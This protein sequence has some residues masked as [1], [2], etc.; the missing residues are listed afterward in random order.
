[1]FR[2]LHHC[3]LVANVIYGILATFIFLGLVERF[4]YLVRRNCCLTLR[5]RCTTA[6][7]VSDEELDQ[8]QNIY[9]ADEGLLPPTLPSVC[10]QL[11]M[12]NEAAVAVRC[13]DA[14]CSMDWPRD[15][16]EVQVLDDSTD[17]AVR[18][19]VDRVAEEW[20]R[21]GVHC[22]VVRRDVR[23]G[24]KAGALE[25][26]R[27]QTDAEFLALFD[28]DFVPRHDFLRRI[29]SRFY[30]R[31]DGAPFTD[32][33]LV[34]AQWTHLNMGQSV[35]TLAQSLW[36]DDHH[37][38]QMNW[39][40]EQW[41]FVNFTGTAGVWRAS[42][43]EA[44]G[45]WRATSLVEDCELS[46]RALFAGYRTTFAR[47]EVPAELPSSVT[48]YKA[49]QKRWTLGWAQ[50][51][52]MHLGTLLFRYHCSLAKRIHLLY[53]IL[54]SVQWPLWL[55]WQ[56]ITPWL[57]A[58]SEAAQPGQ[59]RQP[60]PLDQLPNGARDL[61][62]GGSM[63]DPSGHLIHVFTS[64]AH[65]LRGMIY[66]APL[67]LHMFLAS[68]IAAAER[69]N[70]PDVRETYDRLVTRAS[71]YT[72]RTLGAHVGAACWSSG[73]RCGRPLRFLLLF[74]RALPT[75]FISAGMLPHQACAWIEG[76]FS[77]SSEFET[78]PKSGSIGSGDARST[79]GMG[80]EDGGTTS[81]ERGGA[82]P[83]RSVQQAKVHW[84][85]LAEVA[86]V[87]YQFTWFL[88]FLSTGQTGAAGGTALPMLAVGGL[89][90]CYGDDREGRASCGC[91]AH[92]LVRVWGAWLSERLARGGR[93]GKEAPLQSTRAPLLSEQGH[94]HHENQATPS[95][96]AV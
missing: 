22:H 35:L 27:K 11:P 90:C 66:F 9:E 37:V 92:D 13:I 83:P 5:K 23:T 32:L 56:V 19:L 65:A 30:S 17:E 69:C 75:A 57:V 31:E 24:Y 72:S 76:I 85:V 16:H 91:A 33:A 67:L 79:G 50:L 10:T 21:R 63:R 71:R 49:Q 81:G 53:H 36:I 87:L 12:F 70:A 77:E 86:F 28:A 60:P 88:Y 2:A 42:A 1:M 62:A 18:A 20:R 6:R 34:Q 52:R 41:Q 15:L 73:E 74:L 64:S 55:A 82:P 4:G 39:R 26:G 68:T 93:S 96:P 80:S 89:C 3:L 40:S 78:T 14:A 7:Y 46:F 84:Y 94:A 8:L 58:L 44:A 48:A 59:A 47:V 54:L 51:I 45:G 38:A 43:I 95:A 25:A 29:V 61:P